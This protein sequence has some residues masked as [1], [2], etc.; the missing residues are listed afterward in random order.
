MKQIILLVTIFLISTSS[1]VYSEEAVTHSSLLGVWTYFF[2]TKDSFNP[3]KLLATEQRLL[4][5][6]GQNAV[7]EILAQEAE[8]VQTT[9][10]NL[11]Y[12]LSFRDNEV[13]LSLFSPESDKVIGAYI[14]MPLKDALEFSSDPKF[15]SQRQLYKRNTPYILETNKK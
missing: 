13:Y 1:P 6:D 12:N 10:Y 7:L 14:R 11:K 15:R 8:F 5:L 4:F 3:D 9:K 2:L